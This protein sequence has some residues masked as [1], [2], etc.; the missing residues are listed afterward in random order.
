MPGLLGYKRKDPFE[1]VIH[2]LG[3]INEE[4]LFYSSFGDEHDEW[5]LFYKR[6]ALT[7]HY[8]IYDAIESTL[9]LNYRCPKC[10]TASSVPHNIQ[11]LK[12]NIPKK[13]RKAR[14]VEK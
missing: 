1:I 3:L 5:D 10:D 2:L 4:T 7:P 9:S 11:F 12:L 13:K 8:I 14:D 6:S